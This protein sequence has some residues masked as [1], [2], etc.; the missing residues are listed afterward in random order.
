MISSLAFVIYFSFF[1]IVHSVLADPRFK[2][3]ARRYLGNS[4]DRWSRLGFILFAL[5]MILPFLYFV[6]AVP[7]KV[8]YIIPFPWSWLMTAGRILALLAILL[9]LRQTGFSQ[10]FG[11]SQLQRTDRTKKH[12]LGRTDFIATC[13]ILCSFLVRFFSGSRPS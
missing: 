1:A 6:I 11:L 8:L 12:H 9:S 5:L 7:S 13:E 3:K 2:K 10:F 4:F